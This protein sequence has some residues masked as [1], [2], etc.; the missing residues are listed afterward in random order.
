M[1]IRNVRVYPGGVAVDVA[2]PTR[3]WPS[4]VLSLG[5]W[6]FTPDEIPAV[7]SERRRRNLLQGDPEP[8]GDPEYS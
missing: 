5:L 7:L 4:E 6:I 3:E 2:A 1:A 8:I